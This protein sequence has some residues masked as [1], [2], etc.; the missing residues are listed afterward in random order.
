MTKKDTKSKSSYTRRTVL[1]QILK[2]VCTVPL[3]P[4]SALAAKLVTSTNTETSPKN[5]APIYDCI[6]LGGGLSG[7]TAANALAFPRS[8]EGDS[9]NLLPRSVLVIEGQS[10]LGGRL[11][12]RTVEGF[13]ESVEM[14]AQYVHVDDKTNDKGKSYSLWKSFAEYGVSLIPIHRLFCGV[15]FSKYYSQLRKHWSIIYELSIPWL[16]K[17]RSEIEEYRGPDMSIKEWIQLK[18]ENVHPEYDYKEKPIVDIYLSG[19]ASGPRNR[20]SIKGFNQDRFTSLDEGDYEYK[21]RSGWAGFVESLKFP[22]KKFVK[23]PFFSGAIPIKYNSQV[24][25]VEYFEDHVVVTVREKNFGYA[26]IPREDIP[27]RERVYHA[28]TAIATF[29]IGILRRAVGIDAKSANDLLEF[30]PPLPRKKIEA[31][32]AIGVGIAAK[33]FIA[34][35]SRF[36]DEDIGLINRLDGLSTMGRTY[37]VPNYGNDANNVVIGAYFCGDEVIQINDWSEERIL[38]KVCEELGEIFFE[39]NGEKQIYD[40]VKTNSLGQKV[41]TYKNWAKDPWFYGND[42]YLVYDP[43]DK[44][45]DMAMPTARKDLA[46]AELTGALHWAGEA[47]VYEDGNDDLYL[48]SH[49]GVTHGAHTSGIRAAKEVAAYLDKLPGSVSGRGTPN[50]R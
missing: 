46:S 45:I 22:L 30:S 12:T 10:R 5:N 43:S 16:L 38:K 19:A 9:I 7:L 6:I 29:P 24:T 27:V 15:A 4:L 11:L 23:N 31:I 1:S 14:G 48:Q 40:R 49:A 37:F 41:Y 33:L 47:T 36:W 39:A 8:S 17:F 34:F 26:G 20:M 21:V 42:S 25:R 3:S 50:R 13:P 2:G 35:E 28:R 32:K 44:A 18:Q